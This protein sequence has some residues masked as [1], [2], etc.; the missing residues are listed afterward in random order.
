MA[1]FS[2]RFTDAHFKILVLGINDRQTVVL[3]YSI[4]VP[5]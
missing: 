4:S 2:Q 5:S 3:I 1:S